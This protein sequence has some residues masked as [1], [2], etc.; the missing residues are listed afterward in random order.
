MVKGNMGAEDI[1]WA[2]QMYFN[3][4]KYMESPRKWVEREKKKKFQLP[5]IQPVNYLSEVFATEAI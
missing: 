3:P 1:N 2:S 5:G 4:W